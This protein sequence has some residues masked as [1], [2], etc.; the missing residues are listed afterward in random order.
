V[1]VNNARVTEG[2]IHQDEFPVRL[3]QAISIFGSVT[4]LAKAIDRSDGA[5]RKWLRGASEPSVSDLRAIATATGVSIQWLITGEGESRLVA[6]GT[7][8]M[9][10]TYRSDASSPVD[11]T[12]LE[13]IMETL[14]EELLNRGMKIPATKRS[15]MV[16]T[17][18]GLFRDRRAIERE[19]VTRLLKVA[20]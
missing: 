3:R 8:E 10:G 1:Q 16:V 5:V 12:L 9:S 18:Y 15:A 14:D 6:R 11:N 2:D 20:V 7:R 4:A 17:L 13:G 19:A